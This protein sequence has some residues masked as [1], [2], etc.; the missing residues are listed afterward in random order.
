MGDA[1]TKQQ[2]KEEGL[3]RMRIRKQLRNDRYRADSRR[4]QDIGCP[5]Y[6][7]RSGGAWPDSNSPTG[8]TQICSY[9]A[10]C[11]SPCNGDC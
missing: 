4:A 10:T 1:K 6:A 8:W 11:Q 2:Y 7:V 3:R 9:W 5:L